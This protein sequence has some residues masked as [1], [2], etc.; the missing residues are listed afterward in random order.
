[1][2]PRMPSG[3]SPLDDKG[4]KVRDQ[5][6]PACHRVRRLWMT[7]G[8]KV[9]DQIVPACHRARRLWMTKGA[10]DNVSLCMPSDT[11]VSEWRKG[12][13]NDH[14]LSLHVIGPVA[15]G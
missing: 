14:N 2:V 7:K 6:V 10:E 4:K 8:E 13:R 15:S 9:R 3:L 1:M 11:T 12:E 5:M